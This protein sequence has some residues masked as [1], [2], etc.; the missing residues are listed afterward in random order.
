MTKVY[1]DTSC[2]NRPFDDQS[3]ERIRLESEAVLAILSRFEKGEWDWLGSDVLID[4]IEQT[5]DVQRLTRTRLLA[6]FVTHSI[7]IGPAEIERAKELHKKGFEPFDALH[8]T[9]AEH[10]R[11]DVFLS[12]DDRLLKL[13]NRLSNELHVRVEN[14]LTWIEEII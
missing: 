13:A 4:E 12:T 3:Q 9:C 5:P 14:P 10:T 1:L 6:S 11:A 2:L 7:A 8:I